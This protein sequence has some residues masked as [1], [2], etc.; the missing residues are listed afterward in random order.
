MARR[1]VL[2]AVTL[3]VLVGLL[4][5]AAV[6]G[7]RSLLAPI[8]DANGNAVTTHPCRHRFTKG[9]VVRAKDVTVSVYNAGSRTGLAM[10]T[11]DALAARGFVKGTAS[12]APNRFTSV[13]FVRVLGHSA[14]DPVAKLVAIQFGPHT[15]VQAVKKRRPGPGV[16][17]I[18]GDGFVGLAKAP[19]QLRAATSSGGC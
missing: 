14:D 5:L 13:R 18:V 9:Q 6:V 16:P 2:S 15:F 7:Y 8:P 11:L 12:N 19:T 10:Q 4:L 3:T 1:S 17:V